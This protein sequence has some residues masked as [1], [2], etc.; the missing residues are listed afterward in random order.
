MDALIKRYLDVRS[1]YGE[2]EVQILAARRGT[3][4]GV[5]AINQAIREI[6]NPRDK[7]SEEDILSFGEMSIRH[8]DRVMQTSNNAK[9][10]VMNGEIGTVMSIDQEEKTASVLF[11][12]NQEPKPMG[13][14]DIMK[15]DL[16][17]AT[18]IHK[19]QGSEFP[20]VL[21]VVSK[22]HQMMLNTNLIYTGITRG[23]KYVE[24]I[25]SPQAMMAS[26]GRYGNKRKTGLE[27]EIN[28]AFAQSKNGDSTKKRKLF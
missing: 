13:R 20:A 18:T 4:T 5:N 6:A 7:L 22:S 25:G 14:E 8:G 23:K 26:I 28:R 9:L 1:R 19:S 12:G 2:N 15:L 10:G 16:A 11:D 24:M 27:T 17:Y 3:K 21:F